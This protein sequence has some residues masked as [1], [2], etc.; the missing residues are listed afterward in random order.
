M[1]IQIPAYTWLLIHISLISFAIYHALLYK[2][3]T[4]AATG[5]I[6]FC[7]FVPFVGAIAYY[8]F[9]I[10]RVQTRALNIRRG[11][12]EVAYEIGE[13]S[14]IP[15]STGETNLQDS[16]LRVTG[17]AASNGNSLRALFGGK[18]A[19][20]SMLE[21]IHKAK[22]T[23]ALSTYILNSDITGKKFVTAMEAAQKRGVKVRVLIDGAGELYS[24]QKISKILK[25]K[26]IQS[27]LFLPPRL[28]PPSVYINLRNHRKILVVDNSVAF[29]GGMNI[30]DQHTS[31]VFADKAIKDVHFQ[32]QGPVVLELAE[33][34][35]RD[36]QF[37]TKNDDQE[38]VQQVS[39]LSIHGDMACRVI[40]DGPDAEL[41]TLAL[42]LQAV[43]STAQKSVDIVT[44]Y[45]IPSREL[46]AILQAASLRGVR[47]RIVLPAKNNLFFMHWA[48]RNTLTELLKW[49]ISVYY[50]S[51]PFAHT[52]LLLID[53][54]YALIGSANIDPRSLRLNFELGIEIFSKSLHHQLTQYVD[55]IILHSQPASFTEL[56][57][58]PQLVRLRDSFFALFS[59]YL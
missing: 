56:A 19:Y 4:R 57:N 12:F 51:P 11:L 38:D 33:L 41:D 53:S 36:W 25:R 22:H 2:R 27:A 35:E 42:T 9:G 23:V 8:L 28:I 6:M 18:E 44:P 59:P 17:R 43:I 52:K 50:Q 54:D 20:A 7:L 55:E 45:F 48:N 3:D 1:P 16:G 34:F 40:P 37:A 5:W 47:V 24:R 30:S 10:N 49:G 13:H 46:I 32:L 21:A 26:N 14:A 31:E 58:R 29:A 39:D 15:F